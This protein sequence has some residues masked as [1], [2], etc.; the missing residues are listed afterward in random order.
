MIRAA[1]RAGP[2]GHHR[3]YGAATFQGT[4]WDRTTRWGACAAW[5]P[6]LSG[7]AGC[8]HGPRSPGGGEPAVVPLLRRQ[9]CIVASMV[10][11]GDWRVFSVLPSS[12]MA[13]VIPP[14][15]D[16]RA[17][18]GSKGVRADIR[19]RSPNGALTWPDGCGIYQK[20]SSVISVI[21][22]A[23]LGGLALAR[24]AD[25]LV[26]LAMQARLLVQLGLGCAARRD[27]MLGL[28][29]TVFPLGMR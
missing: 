26:R 1:R 9:S 19:P 6:G 10:S 23:E 16:G 11:R 4:S 28:A 24:V 13:E 2:P 3:Y 22:A 17:A 14:R 12:P 7:R 15:C 25:V 8:W 21:P 27:H 18:W 5:R 20:T 29:G